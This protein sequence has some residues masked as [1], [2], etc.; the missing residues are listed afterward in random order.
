MTDSTLKLV[1]VLDPETQRYKPTRHNLSASEAVTLAE[2]LSNENKTARIIDQEKRH[3]S[4]DIR[5]CRACQ[6]AAET[7]AENG[8]NHP[9]PIEPVAS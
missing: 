9:Q 1:M 4:S 5:R 8:D 3:L 6:K 7:A 2:Q